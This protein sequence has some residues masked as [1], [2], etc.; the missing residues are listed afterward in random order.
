MLLRHPVLLLSF[1]C[2]SDAEVKP[3]EWN[4]PDQIDTYLSFYRQVQNTSLKVLLE[5]S[6]KL[7]LPYY[8]RIQFLE[9]ANH[10][11]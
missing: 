9:M 4:T 5:T 1:L 11:N 6:G 2:Q 10:I 3:C 8:Y 7:Q